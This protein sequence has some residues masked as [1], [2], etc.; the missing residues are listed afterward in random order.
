MTYYNKLEVFKGLKNL[1]QF[2]ELYPGEPG[3]ERVRFA[4]LVVFRTLLSSFLWY[5]ILTV[6][7]CIESEWDLV[8]IPGALCG[9]FGSLQIFIIYLDFRCSKT[10]LTESVDAMQQLVEQSWFQ[11]KKYYYGQTLNFCNYFVLL[12]MLEIGTVVQHLSEK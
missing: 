1:L 9:I 4:K 2:T 7:Y 12:R 6:W 5:E 10:L 11:N 8:N 3:P